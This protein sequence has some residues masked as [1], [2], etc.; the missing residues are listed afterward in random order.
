MFFFFQQALHQ[1]SK[2]RIW[3]ILKEVQSSP[4]CLRLRIINNMQ[5][6]CILNKKIYIHFFHSNHN[7]YKCSSTLA[8]TN[9]YEKNGPPLVPGLHSLMVGF[10]LWALLIP[11]STATFSIGSLGP[12]GSGL[13]VGSIGL[14]GSERSL[15]SLAPLG[16][17]AP[18]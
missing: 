14:L 13:P 9:K 1:R 5:Y 10:P 3:K 7:K 8:S 17:Q 4:C 16:S 18:L 15:G 12:L 11:G 6:Y 2:L